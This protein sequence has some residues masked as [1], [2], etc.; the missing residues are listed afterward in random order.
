MSSPGYKSQLRRLFVV[1]VLGLSL[2]AV[3][4][5]YAVYRLQRSANWVDHTDQV[6]AVLSDLQRM[7]LEVDNGIRGYLITHDTGLLAPENA[8]T[9]RIH[10]DLNRLGVLVKDNSEQA[11]RLTQLRRGYETWEAAVLP[12]GSDPK[13]TPKTKENI[14]RA[15]NLMED[16]RLQ[17]RQ[18]R[19][20]EDELRKQRVSANDLT[21]HIVY[22][23]VGL[24]TVLT[25]LTLAVWTSRTA[26]R[27]NADYERRLADARA[28]HEE[29]RE[30][31]ELVDLA[32]ATAHAGFWHFDPKTDRTILTAG[33]KRLFGLG[34]SGDF[35]SQDIFDRIV[36]EDRERVRAALNDAI[37]TGT[38]FAEFRVPCDDGS[39][40]WLVG[41]A[42]TL[43]TPAGEPY[44]AGINLDITQQKLAEEALLRNEKLAIVG[45]MAA[46]IS[47]EINNPLEAVTNLLYL[48]ED[49]K[50]TRLNS[51]HANISYAV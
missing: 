27:M 17:V 26:R 29:L 37:H 1:P 28:L 5:G 23:L 14:Y 34:L 30:K 4:L 40:R 33:C 51:S 9:P 49:R 10:A 44:V 2:L 13:P 42:R 22:W 43:R 36:P 20:A 45:R 47:H 11:D 38:Y 46:A 18:M 16:L 48:I 15:Q 35:T 24:V 19:D 31:N 3:F 21:L 41:Q 12:L 6:I 7:M 25:G 32:Q 39:V 50:S 8:S